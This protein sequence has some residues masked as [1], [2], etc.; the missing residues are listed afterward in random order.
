MAKGFTLLEVVGV[1]II[2]GI[3]AAVVLSRV[4]FQPEEEITLDEIKNHIRYAQLS[5]MNS[6]YV[7]GIS[8]VP[9]GYFYFCDLNGNK[10]IDD[11]EKMMLPGMDEE[12]VAD[13]LVTSNFLLVFDNWGRPYSDLSLNSTS[14]F[15]GDI[16]FSSGL[17][18]HVT[19]ETGFIN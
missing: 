9:G 2:V 13:D 5:A 12:D 11:S 17:K 1:L 16:E 3:I 7:C 15:E 14:Q 4:N 18:I 8:F 10:A 19:K 6:N